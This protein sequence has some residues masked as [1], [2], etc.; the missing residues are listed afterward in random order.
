ML[1]EAGDDAGHQSNER[2]PPMSR[3]STPSTPRRFRRPI[4]AA[5]VALCVGLS[6]GAG[7]SAVHADEP[8]PGELRA[9]LERACA[10]VEQLETR[11]ETALA[12]I[13]GDATTPGSIA[14]L[15]AKIAEAEAAGRTQAVTV[16][17]N[18]L[19]ARTA[20]LESL[21]TKLTRVATVKQT[22]AAQGIGA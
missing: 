17:Q 5:A 10:R 2:T 15:E 20:A 19:T 22:C 1:T 14:W 13:N 21:N 9:R 11:I 8:A 16:L 7:T 12:R 6:V 4:A 3:T 18:R